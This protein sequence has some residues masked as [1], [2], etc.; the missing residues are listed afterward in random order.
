[1]IRI[2]LFSFMYLILV[3]THAE[4]IQIEELMNEN[5]L[6]CKGSEWIFKFSNDMSEQKKIGL[7]VNKSEQKLRLGNNTYFGIQAHQNYKTQNMIQND[8]AVNF[9]KYG[10]K[11]LKIAFQEIK[12]SESESGAYY[13]IFQ[14][15]PVTVLHQLEKRLGQ[16]WNIENTLEATPQ[17]NTK[18]SCVYIG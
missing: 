18:L 15:K 5:S 14:G 1:M 11:V 17:G 16:N 3:S 8:F 6:N 7:K 12:T 10:V 13:F 2:F 9:Q 4:T